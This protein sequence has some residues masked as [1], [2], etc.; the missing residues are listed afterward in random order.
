MERGEEEARRR[1]TCCALVVQASV[2]KLPF[3]RDFKLSKHQSAMP[4]TKSEWLAWC[5]RR[6]PA[7]ARSQTRPV[8]PPLTVPWHARTRRAAA[9]T[10]A[11]GAT[12]GVMVGCVLGLAPLW[13]NG[14]FFTTR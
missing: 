8:H 11:I 14:T 10:K 3:I 12:I 1:G 2:R 4:S 9:V 13:Y 6:P 7:S 5:V